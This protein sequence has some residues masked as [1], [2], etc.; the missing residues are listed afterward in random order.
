MFQK[1]DKNNISNNITNPPQI[2]MDNNNQP[3]KRSIDSIREDL[4][5]FKKTILNKIELLEN[6]IN[7]LDE[8]YFE[9]KEKINNKNKPNN[10]N[11]PQIKTENNET[12]ITN[13]RIENIE[14][15][16]KELLV[17]GKLSINN[18]ENIENI[19]NTINELQN[20]PRE[21]KL[22]EDTADEIERF[23]KLEK[24]IDFIKN[25]QIQLTDD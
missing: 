13:S 9:L 14:K 19:K 25:N 22:N 24:E 18:Y 23:S 7:I 12:S 1:K 10:P 16:L 5:T 11:T 17:F 2:I 15:T 6:S 8:D 21:I 20:I 4:D 3:L